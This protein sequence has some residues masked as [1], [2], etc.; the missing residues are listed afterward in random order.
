MLRGGSDGGDRELV[1]PVPPFPREIED[2]IDQYLERQTALKAV[3]DNPQP[4]GQDEGPR[5]RAR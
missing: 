2:R 3:R 5:A 1:G 4:Q